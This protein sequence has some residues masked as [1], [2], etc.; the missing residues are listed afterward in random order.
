MFDGYESMNTKDMT[1]QRRS[2]G[3]AGATVTVASNMTT[4]MK[5][6]QFLANR[7]NKQQ[8]IFMLS[9]ELEKNNCK[10][11]HASGDADFL[12]VQSATTS[13]TVLVGDN[14]DLIVLL[15]YHAKLE[16]HDL[17]I[18]PEPKKNTKKLRIWNIKAT[19]EKLGV[20]T[21]AATSSSYMH[22]LGVT[23]HHVC[24]GLEREYP[25]ASLK[26]AVCSMSKQRCS[27]LIQPPRVMW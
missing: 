27:I 13:N 1:H 3:K 9:R 7:K 4:T 8:F 23:P 10:A 2:K 19:K 6:D 15:C 12:T 22:F 25:L 21:S 18:C 16:S 14:T 11:Y 20:K 24:M 17:F 5:K 26:Q